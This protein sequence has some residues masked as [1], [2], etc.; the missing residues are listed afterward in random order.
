LNGLFSF[1]FSCASC[2]ASDFDFRIYE[3][4]S[5]S[6]DT[7]ETVFGT[8]TFRSDENDTEIQGDEGVD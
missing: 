1:L 4:E 7:S 6:H 2:N 5:E 8:E 3:S